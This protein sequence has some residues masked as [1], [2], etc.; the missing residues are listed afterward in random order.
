[1]SFSHFVMLLKPFEVLNLDIWAAFT[2]AVPFIW[3]KG[4]STSLHR[5]AVPFALNQR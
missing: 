2:P 5:S 1:M 3:A 4:D